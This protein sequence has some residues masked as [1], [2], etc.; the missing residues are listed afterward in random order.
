MLI[1]EEE[2]EAVKRSNDLISIIESRGIKLK[3]KGRNYIGLCPF[4]KDT[5]PSLSVNPAADLWKCFGCDTG[6]DVIRFVGL[7]DRVDF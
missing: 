1:P 6:G 3:A 4:H 2:I 7:F 5:N